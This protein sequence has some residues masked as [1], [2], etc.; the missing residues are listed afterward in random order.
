MDGNCRFKFLK[1]K[2]TLGDIGKKAASRLS[3]RPVYCDS[4]RSSQACPTQRPMPKDSKARRIERKKNR[5]KKRRKLT[6]LGTICQGWYYLCVVVFLFIFEHLQLYLHW[7][8]LNFYIKKNRENKKRNKTVEI[9]W[10][11]RAL[12]HPQWTFLHSTLWC[13][14]LLVKR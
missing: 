12:S 13:Q 4:D 11:T 1:N 2:L 14:T 9:S 7:P 5:L 10:K 6:K 3:R 8:R